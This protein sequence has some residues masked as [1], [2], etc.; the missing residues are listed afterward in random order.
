MNMN[1]QNIIKIAMSDYDLKNKVDPK[2]LKKVIKL[3]NETLNLQVDPDL[4]AQFI[5]DLEK[6]GLKLMKYETTK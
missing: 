6:N 5:L 2:I 3:I 4:A 1:H